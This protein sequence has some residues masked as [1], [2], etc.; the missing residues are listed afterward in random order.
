M[1]N[2][3]QHVDWSRGRYPAPDITPGEFES[4]VADLFGA[5]MDDAIEDLRVKVQEAVQGVDGEYKFDATVRYRLGGMDFLVVVEAKKHKNS[6]EREL[7]Q[8]LKDKV[9]SVGAQ[10]GVMIATAPFQSGAIE[11]AGTH[12]IALVKV[13]EGRY[14]FETR[15]GDPQPVMTREEARAL[16][17]PDFVGHVYRPDGQIVLVSTEIADYIAE[18]VLGIEE[19]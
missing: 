5:V 4:F 7:V 12:G 10:K 1:T 14:T 11:Y 18:M 16:G 3:G 2:E 19:R 9:H 6:I 13:T 17:S 8:V 15:G